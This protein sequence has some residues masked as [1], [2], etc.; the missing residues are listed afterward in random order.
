MP[1]VVS[2]RRVRTLVVSLTVCAAVAAIAAAPSSAAPRC[3]WV[4]H[5]TSG[6]QGEVRS[7]SIYGGRRDVRSGSI[8]G[9]R[10]AAKSGSIY[11]AHGGRTSAVQAR[12]QC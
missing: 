9:A 5:S 1:R 2:Y 3:I 8:Y 11:G 4:T 10:R 12:F 6:A 7:G